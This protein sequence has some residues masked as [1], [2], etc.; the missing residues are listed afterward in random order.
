MTITTTTPNAYT[1]AN[2]HTTALIHWAEQIKNAEI[3]PGPYRG[4]PASIIVAAMLGE[5]MGLSWIQSLYRIH[6]IDGKPSASAELIASNVRAA[7]H[8]LRVETSMNPLA[9]RAVIIRKDDP[10]FEFVA[11]WNWERA[12]RA[13]L[14]NKSNW[15]K[16]PVAMLRS[17]AT[18]EAARMAC[19]DALYGV[20]YA[21]GE[22]GGPED[23]EGPENGAQEPVGASEPVAVEPA[24]SWAQSATLT[25]AD[26]T[27]APEPVEEPAP[28]PALNMVPPDEPLV[29][30]PETPEPRLITESQHRMMFSLFNQL[31]EFNSY[32]A[33]SAEGRARRM[34]FINGVLGNAR[35]GG[36]Y[37]S[38]SKELTVTNAARVI[39]RLEALVRLQSEGHVDGQE[40]L[41]MGGN[42]DRL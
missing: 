41:P 34:L 25:P 28:E 8:T 18:T 40:A 35:T 20:V 33:N 42:D 4:R 12:Q 11:V 5:G 10:G 16:D 27:P 3:L 32:A 37:L 31:H 24:T 36:D 6:V 22:V 21:P 23:A 14:V 2:N 9:A 26:F 7:G 17:R 30:T 29:P 1:P 13:G 38:S 19:P 39:D 15:Q